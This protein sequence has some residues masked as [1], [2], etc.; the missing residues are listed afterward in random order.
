M[1]LDLYIYE[2]G[3]VC[4][5]GLLPNR[6]SEN[7]QQLHAPVPRGAIVE[8]LAPDRIEGLRLDV[9][10]SGILLE[11]PLQLRVDPRPRRGLVARRGR[12]SQVVV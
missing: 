2:I 10:E 7:G 6:Y 5:S 9:D 1:M 8:P 12:G 4:S 3:F 11:E